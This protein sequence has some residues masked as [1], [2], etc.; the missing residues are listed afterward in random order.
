MYYPLN[1]P[2]GSS[3]RGLA[4]AG[5]YTPYTAPGVGQVADRGSGSLNVAP[6]RQCLMKVPRSLEPEQV[7]WAITGQNTFPGRLQGGFLIA[8][9]LL[10]VFDSFS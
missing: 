8:E 9:V 2:S 5:S 1:W 7:L 3:Q 4:S 6:S 10:P